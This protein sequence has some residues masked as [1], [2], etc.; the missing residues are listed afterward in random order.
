MQYE[1]ALRREGEAY[2]A[3]GRID[4]VRLVNE[5]LRA[6]GAA[7]IDVPVETSV[8]RQTR[9]SAAATTRKKRTAK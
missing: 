2:K 3:V 8:P 9:Q 6:I 1:N 7:E 4:R 5:Q